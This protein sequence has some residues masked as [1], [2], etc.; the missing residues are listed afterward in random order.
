MHGA[1]I[2][3]V[4]RLFQSSVD[5][6]DMDKRQ[7]RYDLWNEVS[8]QWSKQVLIWA[9]RTSCR[10][11]DYRYS[12][13]LNHTLKHKHANKTKQKWTGCRKEAFNQHQIL[14]SLH[15]SYTLGKTVKKNFI[16]SFIISDDWD[17][18]ISSNVR[19]LNVET[20]AVTLSNRWVLEWHQE[21]KLLIRLT[22]WGCSKWR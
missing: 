17:T 3:I 7:Q 6:C 1:T 2:K 14:R 20:Q 22:K 21:W 5:Q 19:V 16:F 13:S 10:R 12:N 4:R 8:R 15:K 9:Q 11:T 18:K